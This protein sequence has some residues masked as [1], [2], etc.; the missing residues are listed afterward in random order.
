M[1]TDSEVF[2]YLFDNTPPSTNCFPRCRT[3]TGAKIIP[4]AMCSNLNAPVYV[5]GGIYPF[6]HRPLYPDWARPLKS[7]EDQL[8]QQCALFVVTQVEDDVCRGVVLTTAPGCQPT[9]K[10]RPG[11]VVE[12]HSFPAAGAY[13]LTVPLHQVWE[14]E[15]KQ[16]GTL[17]PPGL[18]YMERNAH[19]PAVTW[20]DYVS[21][22]CERQEGSLPRGRKC[23]AGAGATVVV[24]TPPDYHAAPT[25]C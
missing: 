15:P 8:T 11:D 12:G 22:V 3:F 4:G 23:S 16:V 10:L 2:P 21:A 20:V 19:G 1:A 24:R 7:C 18:A 13:F 9:I 5:R 25:R 6:R 14:L 17:T